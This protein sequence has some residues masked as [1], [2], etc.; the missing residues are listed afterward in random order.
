MLREDYIIRLIR[1]L[2]A[3][4]RR[5]AGLRD[6]GQLDRAMDEAGRAYEDLLGMPPGLSG[7]MDSAGIAELCGSAD[8]IRVAARLSWE[9]GTLYK[10]KGD[11]LAAFGRFRRAL[12]L[13]LE[14][15]ALE[16][17]PDDDAAILELS[18]IVPAAELDAR[19]RA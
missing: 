7:M 19:Y 18:R 3:F 15:R 5:I 13:Y 8:K 2:G 11:P 1:D 6:E 14:A 17:Q 9:E 16:P 10:A 12:E 4:V